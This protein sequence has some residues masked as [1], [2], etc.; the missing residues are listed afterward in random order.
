M[1]QQTRQRTTRQRKSTP[2][3]EKRGGTRQTTHSR[4]ANTTHQHM[5][6]HPPPFQA[7]KGG[8][9]RKT[10]RRKT[11]EENTTR[12]TRWCSGITCVL[13]G[14]RAHY[15]EHQHKEEERKTERRGRQTTRPHPPPFHN[16]QHSTT[17]QHAPQH[18]KSRQWTTDTTRPSTQHNRPPPFH[19][20]ITLSQRHNPKPTML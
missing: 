7:Q 20:H 18:I 17:G 19:N 1:Q 13:A 11:R 5:V 16:P 3:P 12:E 4:H 15:P 10:E 2:L 8:T 14:L 6:N 9:Q